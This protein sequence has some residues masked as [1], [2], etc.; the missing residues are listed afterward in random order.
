[1]G[2]GNP[3]ELVN[4][5]VPP[6]SSEEVAMQQPPATQLQWVP[7][8]SSTPAQVPPYSS[9]EVAMQQPPATQLQW[10]PAP[11]STA[12][13]TNTG[14]N[15]KKLYIFFSISAI[16]ILAIAMAALI[17]G[18]ANIFIYNKGMAIDYSKCLKDMESCTV[19]PAQ[20]WDQIR[21]ICVTDNLKINVTVSVF[22][23][24]QRMW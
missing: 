23:I 15:S 14:K 10:V 9:E 16:V 17:L 7:A 24:T 6:Y 21:Y 20:G 19:F 11:N 3:V 1:M 8:A 2:Y 4:Y 12:A 13:P 5:Q 18:I 22:V